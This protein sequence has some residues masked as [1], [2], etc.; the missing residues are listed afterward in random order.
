MTRRP[1]GLSQ[2]PIRLDLADGRGDVLGDVMSLGLLRNALYKQIEAR[3]PW[4]MDVKARHRAML[5]LVA[6]GEARLEMPGFPPVVL[7]AGHIAFLP[8]GAAHVLR[9]A[10]TT[11]PSAVCDGTVGRLAS[12]TR[13]IGGRGAATLIVSAFFEL[14]RT[15]PPLLDRPTQVVVLS[16]ETDPLVATTFGLVLAELEHPGPAS[17]LLLQRLTDVLVVQAM[18]ALT[19]QPAC[20]TQ[21]SQGLVALSDPPIHDALSLMH[22][23][24]GHAWSV[25]ELAGRVGL[26]R[27]GFAARFTELVGEPPLQYLARWRATCAAQLLRETTDPVNTIATRVGYDSTPSFNKAFQRWQGTTPTAY[28]RVATPGNLT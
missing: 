26:S 2:T 18:R 24:V 28:R 7:T 14:D 3:A 23:Q 11:A 21:R 6:R 9:D 13:R 10:A 25:E 22:A 20:R 16:G 27:S 15:P 19:K 8:R 12:T 5:Y 1:S 4:G 17:V